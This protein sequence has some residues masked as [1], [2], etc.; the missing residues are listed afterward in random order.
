M[1][2]H[3]LSAPLK[4]LYWFYAEVGRYVVLFAIIIGGSPSLIH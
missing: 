2:L 3:S 1:Q 4:T